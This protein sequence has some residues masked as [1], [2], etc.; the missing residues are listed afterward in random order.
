MQDSARR[1]DAPAPSP[2]ARGSFVACACAST[3]GSHGWRCARAGPA[4]RRDRAARLPAGCRARSSSPSSRPR[5]RRV[6]DNDATLLAH[7]GS[8]HAPADER[9]ARTSW[10]S[11]GIFTPETASRPRA[12]CSCAASTW[13]TTSTRSPSS[14]RRACPSGSSTTTTRGH[15]ERSARY[16]DLLAP[17]GIPHE[18]R[19][20]FVIRGRVVGRRA[21]RPPRGERAVPA[22]RRRRA[23][24]GSPA[25]SPAASARR[26]ASTPPAA[27]TAPRR[28]ASSC[29][30]RATRSSS[31]RRP[32][33][34]CSTRCAARAGSATSSVPVGGAARSPR[35]SRRPRPPAAD[36]T[37]SPFPS[38]DGW[39]TLHASLPDAAGDGRV[40]I[41]I[42]RAV[43]R[44]SAHRAAGGA[45][46]DR[47]RARG[48]HAARARPEQAGDRRGARALAAHGPGPRQEPLR[49]ARR[50]RRARS[51]S[52]GCSST[53]TCPR[54]VAADAARLDGTLRGA[55][56]LMLLCA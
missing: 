31:S 36:P 55:P 6:I 25:R 26:C 3:Y 37:S 53:S 4:D 27:S 21:R 13:S 44:Q 23:R 16:R 42:E 43:G 15:P 18:L 24:R 2:R 34:S 39:I 30:A 35:S 28:R 32:P 19:A 1:G 54:C 56:R 17:A 10:S 20:A 7:A 22:A 51:S 40:A 29:S 52:P 49:E 5:L 45:R 11:A 41:V 38:D 46:R 14:P 47:A 9:R 50:R 8:A 33:A 48:R 12:S